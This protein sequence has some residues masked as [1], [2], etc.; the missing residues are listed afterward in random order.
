M[1]QWT[2]QADR[3]RPKT[4]RRA[5]YRA[6]PQ[7]V[8]A[9]L[10][11]TAVAALGACSSSEPSL[12]VS[13]D[14]AKAQA[15]S[16]LRSVLALAPDTWPPDVPQ[17]VANDCEVGGRTAVQF[18]YFVEALR[19]ADPEALV[20]RTGARW[21]REGYELSTTRTEMDPETGTVSAVVARADGKPR[22]ST[23]ATRVRA[24]VSVDS[25]C[26]AGDP[27]GHR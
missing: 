22:A 2:A 27:D 15:V 9:L 13:V 1:L 19:P 4:G 8:S 21:K 17:H 11:V 12:A 10:A 5:P 18:S 25:L 16:E 6:L 23:A 14:A 20:E 24:H 7:G 3:A 26:V